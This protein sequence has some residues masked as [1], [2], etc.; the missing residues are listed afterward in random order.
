MVEVARA[1]EVGRCSHRSRMIRLLVVGAGC[2]GTRW[3]EIDVGEVA[4][5]LYEP[6]RVLATA[7][8]AVAVHSH[9]RPVHTVGVVRAVAGYTPGLQDGCRQS[10]LRGWGERR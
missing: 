8:D 10:R 6:L 7:S 3:S 4:G 5:E 9:R 1:E 2:N